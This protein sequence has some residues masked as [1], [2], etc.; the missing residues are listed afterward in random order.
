MQAANFPLPGARSTRLT[1]ASLR[2]TNS[3]AVRFDLRLMGR[4]REDFVL[5]DSNLETDA[6]PPELSVRLLGRLRFMA[7]AAL[8]VHHDEAVRGSA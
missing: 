5:D 7:A 1:R 6:A 2:I 3:C 8:P 4:P